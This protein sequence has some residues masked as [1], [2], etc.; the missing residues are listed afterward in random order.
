MGEDK[1]VWVLPFNLLP[2]AKVFHSHSITYSCVTFITSC[3]LPA[4]TKVVTIRSVNEID[5]R[6][7]QSFSQVSSLRG[8]GIERRQTSLASLLLFHP[9][10]HGKLHSNGSEDRGVL[11]RSSSLHQ[12]ENYYFFSIFYIRIPYQMQQRLE[13]INHNLFQIIQPLSYSSF[14]IQ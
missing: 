8:E 5:C 4:V 9:S 2:S 13:Q 6:R 7:H 10:V 14:S 11:Q 3:L 1:C 12:M